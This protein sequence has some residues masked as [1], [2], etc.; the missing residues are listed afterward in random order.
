MSQQSLEDSG[1]VKASILGPRVNELALVLDTLVRYVIDR[2]HVQN[3]IEQHG[4]YR[5]TGNFRGI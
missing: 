5:M 4:T 3:R 2:L 1:S